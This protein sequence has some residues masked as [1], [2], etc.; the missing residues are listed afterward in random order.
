LDSYDGTCP[1]CGAKADYYRLPGVYRT[2]IDGC[3]AWVPDAVVGRCRGCNGVVYPPGES[4]A[5]PERCYWRLEDVPL[6][7]DGLFRVISTEPPPYPRKPF[8]ETETYKLLV[9]CLVKRFRQE[10][11]GDAAPD[12]GG[13][14]R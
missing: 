8:K 9:E 7:N 6:C 1:S 11:D 4:D 5:W 2:Q 3:D 13:G 10:R 14:P 12:H